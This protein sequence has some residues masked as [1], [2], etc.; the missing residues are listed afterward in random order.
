MTYSEPEKINLHNFYPIGEWKNYEDSM[1]LISETGTI[2]LLYNAKEVNIVSEGE[3]RLEIY[4]D[5]HPISSEYAG[6]DL[7]EGIVLNVSE[8]GL[9]N[10]VRNEQSS[11]HEME[12]KVVGKGFQIFTFTFG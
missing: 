2:K 10:I 3:A 6:I 8:P 12:I 9:Y 7:I 5:G 4:L 1:E 11:T